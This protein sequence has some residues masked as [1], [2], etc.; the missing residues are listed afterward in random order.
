M[1]ILRYFL[2]IIITAAL[3]YIARNN[4]EGRPES[5]SRVDNDISFEM[6]TMPKT[7]ER[8]KAALFITIRGITDSTL[9]P[10]IR[11]SKFG[12]DA[13]TPL[14]QY[15]STP[16]ILDDSTSSIYRAD[17]SAGVKGGRIYYYFE[18]R[19][20]T[21]GRRAILADI[22][23]EPF[24]LKFIGH[25]PSYV[26]IAHIVFIFSAVFMVTLSLLEALILMR[27]GGDASV[28]MKRILWAT[29]L[30]FVGGY[31]IGF[32]MNWYA[33]GG[34]W[35]GVP[36]GTDATDNKTQLVFFYLLFMLA[37][38]IRSLSG[39]F[40]RDVFNVKTLGLL[41]VI[42]FL[43]Q[44]VVNL[45]PHSIQFEPNSTY[46]VCYGFIAILLVVYL[47]GLF[48]SVRTSAHKR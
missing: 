41:G 3:L 21:G 27:N 24:L 42:A 45:I 17:I 11:T 37:A 46:L 39:K 48:K 13:T 6:T 33:F 25:V 18:V 8:N 34:I 12:Q 38:G 31:P 10:V 2:A 26:L 22:A 14:H 47:I 4:S 35:E 9:T 36:F 20:K 5:V 40:G 43:V 30:F 23:G 32:A 29:I 7:A 15:A 16:L 44:L 28:M 19:D 1:K